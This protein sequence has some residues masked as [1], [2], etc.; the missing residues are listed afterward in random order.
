MTGIS[1]SDF[2]QRTARLL[3]TR[4]LM[5][6]TT[7]A[8]L[9]VAGQV[10]VQV[11]LS[12]QT[13][14]T[15]LINLAG[16][17]R[18][19]SQALCKNVL[20]ATHLPPS[21][22]AEIWDE[23]A[24]IM[25]TFTRVHQG[26]QS[27]DPHLDLP[28]NHSSTIHPLLTNLEPH[29]AT[30]SALIT[31]AFSARHLPA[32][33]VSA[34]LQAQR[35]YLA[36]M[37]DVV[38]QLDREAGNRLSEIRILEGILWALLGVVLIIESLAV[39]RPVI[40]RIRLE[41]SAREHRE[42]VAIE[43]EIAELSGRL[44]RRI[45]QDLHDG[46]GQVLTGISFQIKALERRLKNSPEAE[47]AAEISDHV[48]QAIGQTRNLARMLHPI[49]ADAHSLGTALRDLAS[50]TQQVFSV[51]TVVV[52]D[53]D[54]P[55]PHRSAEQPTEHQENTPSIHLFRLAQ[56]AVSNAIRHG[57]ARHLWITGVIE[58]KRCEFLIED[59]GIGFEPPQVSDL[60]QP[61]AG[62]GLRIMA[63]R[64]ERIGASF[65]LERRAAGGTRIILR[66]ASHS[67]P[68]YA[69]PECA[70]EPYLNITAKPPQI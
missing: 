70:C 14:D 64:A 46:L 18:N 65:T 50:T 51:P 1:Q 59:D 45:G 24:S 16:R 68:G 3:T 25:D 15:H 20:A 69:G 54:L 21:E 44:E 5:A 62:M 28:A 7:V 40:R 12:R 61:R 26:L 13:H 34:L 66:W 60:H 27:G 56:E 38:A 32:P 47:S 63:F 33:D 30:L 10:L 43:S 58:N 9:S 53:D 8:L 48:S 67:G 41:I 31:Q 49:E 52:W 39:F 17:Q 55:L 42:T 4:Y 36:R 6:L 29:F 35:S 37:E 57:K 2:A 22:S 19:Y 11:G 23:T